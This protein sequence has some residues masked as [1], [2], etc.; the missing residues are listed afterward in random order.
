MM[1]YIYKFTSK[2]QYNTYIYILYICYIFENIFRLM[3]LSIH[4]LVTIKTAAKIISYNQS[5]IVIVGN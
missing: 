2:Y 5:V 4:F 3:S 1:S